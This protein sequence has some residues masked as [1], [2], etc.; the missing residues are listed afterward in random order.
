MDQDSTHMVA[1]SK[2]PM[3]KLENI[4]GG[5][6]ATRK[7]QRNLLKQQYEN[8]TVLSSEMLDQTFDKL[9]K[10]R[11]KVD[12]DTMSTD[13][14]YNNLKSDQAEEGPNYALMAFSSL[15]SDSKIVYNRKKGLGYENYN[16]VPP[17][18]IENFMSSTPDLSFTGLDEFVN[19][20]VVENYKAISSEEEPKI[21]RKYDDALTILV[22]TAR[23]VNVAHSKTTVNAA[24]PIPYLSKTAHSTVK[25]P[26]H[27]NTTF[28][29]SNINQRVNT[30]RGK[31]LNTARTKAVVNALKG[32]NFNTLRPKAVVNAIKGN[33]FNAVKASAY[34]KEIDGGYVA[35]GGNPKGG[36]IT[37]KEA[38]SIACYVQNRVLVVKP[39]NKTP[40][41]LFYGRT[42]ALSFMRSFGC[43]VTILNTIDHFGKFDGKADEGSGP[44]WLF[45]IDALTRT[46]NYEPIITGT[47]SNGFADPKS[48][49]DDGSKPSSDDGKKDEEDPRRKSKCK[50]Q[51][52]E[53]NVNNTNNVNTVGN[54]NTVSSTV[55]AAGTNDVNAIGGKISIKLLFDP[56]LPALEDDSIFDFL[57][58]DENDG[59]VADMNNLDTTIHVSP[60][61]TTRIHKDHTFDQVIGDLQSAIQT[62]KMFIEVKTAFTPME[63][64]KPLLKDEDGEEV[65]VH[66][67]R[68]MIGS[69]MYLTSLR[70]DIMFAVCACA[71]YQ[72]NQKVSH[73]YAVKRIF[74]A[75]LDR[76]SITGGCQFFVCR[77]I[78][79]QC[80]K[81][82]VVENSTTE[83]KYVAAS[84]CCGQVLW[85]QNQ[86]LDYGHNLLL[87][88]YYYWVKVNTVEGLAI[89]TDP[90][91]T[92]TIIQPPSQPQKKQQPRKPKRKDTQLPQ[93][94]D[95]IKNVADEAVHKELGDSLKTKTTQ[96]NEISSL[97]RR[98]KK[99]EK[100][101]R[102]RTHRLKRL[103]KVGL[104]TM[105]ES[106][107][108]EK[109]LGKDASKLRRIDAIDA[110]EEIALVNV[111][112][113]YDKEIFDVNVLDAKRAEEK[114]NKPLTKAQQRKIMCTY[115]KNMKGYKL[116]D[117]KL[118][119]FDFIQEM[120]DKAFKRQKVK[121]DKE[122]AELKQ[123]MEIIP[124]E[125]VAIDVIPLAVK[126]D[127]ENL[128]K[129]VKAKY[130]STR[131]VEDLDLLLWGDLKSMFK[132]HV[133][134]EIYMLVDKKYPLTPPILLMMLEKKLQIDYESK[135]A[136]Q[137][138]KFIKKQIKNTKT[139]HRLRLLKVNAAEKLQLL[140][141][142]GGMPPGRRVG[143]SYI[144]QIGTTNVG[145]D[146]LDNC[147]FTQ[148][149]SLITSSEN[150][151]NDMVLLGK[152]KN[153]P[154]EKYL[155]TY[156]NI[157]D[158]V[159]TDIQGHDGRF[160]AVTGSIDDD[161]VNQ[162]PD[163]LR[164]A[165][166]QDASHML[167]EL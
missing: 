7:T 25:R 63:T 21:V 97:K 71:R 146:G 82:T 73:L 124:D 78:P 166:I 59:A 90:H 158:D 62:R 11:Y 53:D 95:P 140:V 20:P 3:L 43:L 65:D 115:L 126:E 144:G 45:D 4:F 121:D 17:P 142:K 14:L 116:K 114:R 111:Q 41:E 91:H 145:N 85:I 93:P 31:K 18:Y 58:D 131:Q 50:D 125:E 86:L 96:H 149:E 40:Y 33:N 107:N 88:S 164:H 57:S 102:S 74:R 83:A 75:S 132:P 112:N 46:M 37:G 51:K 80:K 6:E 119:E 108:N 130:E 34:Y 49:N 151:K 163:T 138:L 84:S 70:P 92:P 27:K 101:N 141:K 122:I 79:W 117:L 161:S 48:S 22:N 55:N 69:L 16:A 68:S 139:A 118:K 54:F 76:K 32:N 47:Q 66:M 13:D 159:L 133:E 137:L 162:Q 155:K 23:Q 2:V 35:F 1:A 154:Q 64:Q 156:K 143:F 29:N 100:K 106:S 42:L 110:D 87:L 150:L 123:F 127:L 10:L 99:L 98:V 61:P 77:L 157:L 56:K 28:K 72:V 103:Y 113:D 30:V 39:H 26:I 160:N 44:D 104:T 136:Y 8:F 167:Q 153:Q 24:R 60:I 81:Q 120:F 148:G 152:K 36:K 134:D 38:V 135:M 52:K 9:Q 129:L 89:P 147:T 67:Y 128:Y 94:S 105:V 19:K 109:S 12:L 5:N 165:V 15:S